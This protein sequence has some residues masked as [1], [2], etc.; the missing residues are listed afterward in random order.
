M[1]DQAQIIEALG[2]ASDFDA[3]LEANRRT[4]FL[5]DLSVVR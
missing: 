1:T 2:V 3:G 5:K 4:D